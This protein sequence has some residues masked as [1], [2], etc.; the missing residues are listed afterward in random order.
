VT[1]SSST[2]SDE[3]ATKLDASVPHSARLWNYWLGG[4]DNFAADR[5]VADQILAMVPEM[6]TSAR[7]DR[8][9]L[10]RVVRHMAGVEGIRQFLDIGTG[11]PTADNTHEVA[12]RVAPT[13]RIV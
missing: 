4:K 11:V 6:V 5:E 1:G 13:S 9:F 7:A 8:E 3:Q 10:G 2:P 12:Q